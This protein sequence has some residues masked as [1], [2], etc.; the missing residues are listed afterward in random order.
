MPYTCNKCNKYFRAKSHFDTHI[1]KKFPCSK[2]KEAKKNELLIN[3]NC[4]CEYCFKLF[5]RTDTLKKH[6]DSYCKA[7]KNKDIQDKIDN[8]Q[9]LKN[10][11]II[12]E[13]LEEMNVLIEQNKKLSEQLA[14]NGPNCNVTIGSNNNNN[15]NNNHNNI[16]NNNN[17]NIT[18]V[19]FGSENFETIVTDEFC[20]KTM[21][22][23]MNAITVFTEHAHLNA[24]HP[25]FHNCY[26]SNMR[27]NHAIIYNNGLWC[28]VN[29]SD[30]IKAITDKESKFL[31]TK[32]DKLKKTMTPNAIKQF[33][34]Y[35]KAKDTDALDKRYNKDLK[36]MFY[37]HKNIVITTR[38]T[39]DQQQKQ[40]QLI[41]AKNDI[42]K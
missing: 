32:Y 42:K 27:D 2:E 34:R 4:E 39:V 22:R 8:D 30:A 13:M 31:E 16:H 14:N 33:D 11:Q 29:A 25:E 1:N 5:A 38:K 3:N 40:Q 12:K 9:N 41:Q 15:I 21:E 23:G 18:L 36:L 24:K 6:I 19:P 17:N 26:I 10:E 20:K 28:L 35:L 7:K 37:N